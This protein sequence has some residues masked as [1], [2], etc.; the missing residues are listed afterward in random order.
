VLVRKE[1]EGQEDASSGAGSGADRDRPG[2]GLEVWGRSPKPLQ[3]SHILAFWMQVCTV[4]C[5]FIEESTFFS[6]ISA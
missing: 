2:G 5:S 3:K 4:L 6:Q 1:Q